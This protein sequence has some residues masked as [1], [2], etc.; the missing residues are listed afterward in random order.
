MKT[1]RPRIQPGFA[2]VVTVSL[3]VLLALVAI[4]M[5]SLSSV[6]LRSGSQTDA[7]STARANARLSLML[8]LGELQRQAG[9]DTRVTARADILSEENPPVLGVWRSW[10]GLNHETSG[11]FAG[12]PK[13]PAYDY[14]TMKDNAYSSGS[15][16]QGR[17]LAWLTSTNSTGSAAAA[18]TSSVPDTAR[19]A[20][21]VALLGPGSVGSAE[22]RE[23]MQIH[24]TPTLVSS[25]QQ[26]GATAWW[27][28]GENQKAYIPK[29]EADANRGSAARKQ[30]VL[31]AKSHGTVDPKPFGLDSV[32]ADPNRGK[33]GAEVNKALTIGQVDLLNPSQS[34]ETPDSRRS[35]EFFH[36]L[37]TSS[38]GLLTNTATGGWR[39]DMSL[40]SEKWSDSG[41]PKSD[42]PFFRLTTEADHS[43]GAFAQVS[44][45]KESRSLFYPWAAYTTFGH[46]QNA[47]Q[48][49]IASW[50]KLMSFASYYK[51]SPNSTGIRTIDSWACMRFGITDADRYRH[52]HTINAYPIIARVQWVFSHFSE[53]AGPDPAA[54]GSFLYNPKLL[55]T[56]VITLWNPYDVKLRHNNNMYFDF[57]LM[58]VALSYQMQPTVNTRYNSIINVD[59][60]TRPKA[61]MDVEMDD[62]PFIVRIQCSIPT[63]GTIFN[64][65]QTIVYSPATNNRMVVRDH[66]TPPGN[67]QIP[68]EKGFRFTG[69]HLYPVKH[70]TMVMPPVPAS[71]PMKV[72]AR[73][74]TEYRIANPA[75]FGADGVGVAMQVGHDPDPHNLQVMRPMSR[76]TATTANLLYPMISDENKLNHPAVQ[77]VETVPV[78]FLSTIYGL[79]FASQTQQNDFVKQYY[80]KGAGQSTPFGAWLSLYYSDPDWGYAYSGTGHPHTSR[81]SY[82][83][84]GYSS[85]GA[86]EYP[87]SGPGPDYNGYI[88]TGEQS[89]KGMPRAVVAELP[90]RPLVSLAELTHFDVRFENPSPPFAFNVI[91]NSDA[92][93]MLP[94]NGVY[95]DSEKSMADNFRHDDFYCAN[96]LLFDDWFFSAI[97]EDPPTLGALGRSQNVVY[98]EWLKGR[99]SD[100]AIVPLA[101]RAYKP[102]LEDQALVA[103]QPAA[104]L[105]DDYVKPTNSWQ[106]I[107]SRLEVEGMFNVN[108]TS[109]AAWRSL[110]GHARNQRVLYMRS[111]G[112][113]VDDG[114]KQH[115]VSRFSISGEDE[116]GSAVPNA[117]VEASE[118]TGYRTLD[119]DFLDELAVEVVKQVRLR[120]PFLSLAEFINRQLT[121]DKNLALAGALQTALNELTKDKNDAS[122]PLATLK[123]LS[124]EITV[125]PP[126]GAGNQNSLGYLAGSSDS[127]KGYSTYG[128]PGWTRQADILRPIAPILSA[129][130]DTFVIRGYGDARDGSGKVIANAVCEA[131]VKRTRDYIDPADAADTTSTLT[132]AANKVFG[133]RFE[134]VSFRWLS[135][136]EV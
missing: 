62:A 129:R 33:T 106:T 54:A 79:R 51:V 49:P 94:L 117:F 131:V 60:Q 20:G 32:L 31:Q 22:E 93:P 63:S 78:P 118:V 108:S 76:Y 110:L 47:N 3:M 12:R 123:N 90:A 104:K 130:D 38:V 121:N 19:A 86:A 91:G 28:G 6:A 15:P 40:L 71:T 56:P 11:A 100:G 133:R 101:N 105:F 85:G 8:A 72:R 116:A 134:I 36:D 61:P 111:D 1:R 9:S 109:V 122:N 7:I 24:L 26:S 10:E 95:N 37:T 58:P 127:A 98:A 29:P 128:V 107:A 53:R 46:P 77:D 124:P 48:H 81:Y 87:G 44:R 120:G 75:W 41:F 126:E 82:S 30:A 80:I 97:T 68:L 125:N 25:G 103:S 16:D 45:Y 96:H 21:K 115:P 39:K 66:T 55:I 113:I 92:S 52:L 34:S 88:I 57:K 27:V 14:R 67:N 83:F 64:P 43:R 69:G 84:L 70:G 50:N 89:D 23:N 17:F 35:R 13:A 59:D 2:L 18:A 73:F 119:D 42:L 114:I 5:L 74:D 65:G 4:G 136:D 102:I 112:G 99:S 132:S 135:P